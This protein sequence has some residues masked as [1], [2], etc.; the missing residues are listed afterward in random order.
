MRSLGYC[1]TVILFTIL[2]LPLTADAFS[3][4]SHNSEVRPSQAVTAPLNNTNQSETANVS[5]QAVPE[6]PA[7]LLMSVGVGLFFM[8]SLAKRCRRQA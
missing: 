5:A 7:L 2:S 8:Y 3:R 1:S 6:P 4:R